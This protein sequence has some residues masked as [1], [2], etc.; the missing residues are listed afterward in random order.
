MDKIVEQITEKLTLFSVKSIDNV[1]HRPHPFMIG[2]RHIKHASDKYNGM[3]GDETLKEIP[4]DM[5]GCNLS[6]DQH[7][8]DKVLFLQ[9]TKSI[10]NKEAQKE[11]GGITNILEENKIDGISLVETKEKF[12]I[13]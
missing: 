2:P 7:T 13:K 10:S 4:C 3:L 6:H 11:L 12:R 5:N 1:N 9:L 8:S